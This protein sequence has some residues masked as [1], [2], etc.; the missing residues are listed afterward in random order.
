[1]YLAIA[2][3]DNFPLGWEVNVNFTFFVHDQIQDNYLAVQGAYL[4]NQIIFLIFVT[5][6]K[7][8]L[9]IFC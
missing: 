8:K 4:L 5:K 3:T 9:C 2:E 6:L 1:M 7:S